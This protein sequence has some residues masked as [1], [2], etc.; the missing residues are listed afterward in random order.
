MKEGLQVQAL[1]AWRRS[2][3]LRSARER[4]RV[5]VVA[6]VSLVPLVLDLVLVSAG[7]VLLLVVAVLVEL[8]GMALLLVLPVPALP[9][10]D[11]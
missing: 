7:M 5:V 3:Q 8:D 2:P 1:V 11:G 6:P 4:R 9:V 10:A